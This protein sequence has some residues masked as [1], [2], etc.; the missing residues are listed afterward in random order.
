MIEGTGCAVNNTFINI[1]PNDVIWYAVRGEIPN[2]EWGTTNILNGYYVISNYGRVK[3]LKRNTAHERIMKPRIGKDGYWYVNLCVN[4]KRYTYKIHRLVA[5][6]FI[7]NP[8]NLPQVNHIDGCKTN[9]RVDNL[10]WC[11]ASYNQIHANKLGLRQHWMKGK[12]GKDCAFSKKINQFDLYGNFI[13]QWDSMSDVMRELNIPV[14]HLVR[15][16]KGQRKSTR[17][18]IWRYAKGGDADGTHSM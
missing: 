16:C 1:T 6:I 17:G 14:S 12:L 3:S 4:G 13:K 7:P 15:V 10:E 8:N 18:F 2:E 9:S 5:T 11:T